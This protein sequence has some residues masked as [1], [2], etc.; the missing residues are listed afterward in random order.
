[1]TTTLHPPRAIAISV[2]DSPDLDRLGLNP[3]HLWDTLVE[4]AIELLAAG[5]DIAYGGD[6]RQQG[7]T[8]VLFELA[9]RYQRQGQTM[10]RVINYLAWPVHIRMSVDD[11]DDT[12]K[13]VKR[14]ARLALIGPD[15][16]RI[17]P[18][19]RR[20]LP[21]HEPDESEWRV[22]LTDMRATMRTET[23]ARIVIGGQVEGYKGRMPGIAEEVLLS[24]EAS[25]PVFLVGGFGGCTRDIAESMGLVASENQ[26]R[27]WTKRERFE[28]YAADAL[29]NGLTIDENQALARTPFIDQAVNL[30]MLGL[31][32]LYRDDNRSLFHQNGA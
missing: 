17:S 18:D 31:Y 9:G 6:L 26:P 20:T 2:S 28:T 14:V 5:V 12:E 30:V 15:G 4:L 19:E 7:F 22:G 16:R 29:H 10:I 25:Q 11:L 3:D 21:S 13:A 23:S 1:M 24:L 32:R 8:E 27:R